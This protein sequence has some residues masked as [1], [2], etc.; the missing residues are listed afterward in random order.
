LKPSF[1]V[2]DCF[3]ESIIDGAFHCGEVVLSPVG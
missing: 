1:C 3:W 2:S